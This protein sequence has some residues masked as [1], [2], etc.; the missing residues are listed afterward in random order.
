MRIFKRTTHSSTSPAHS[1]DPL[2]L[3]EGW[4]ETD[5]PEHAHVDVDVSP[6]AD[7]GWIANAVAYSGSGPF[8]QLGTAKAHITA[9]G[10]LLACS[11]A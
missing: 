2:S 4:V 8:E 11:R 1:V 5:L 10:R 9:S 3:A 6:A 7:G